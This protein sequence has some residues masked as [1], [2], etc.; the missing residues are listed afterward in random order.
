MRSQTAT[1]SAVKPAVK[2]AVTTEGL[3]CP[4]CAAGLRVKQGSSLNAPD[5]APHGR[6]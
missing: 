6:W 3:A 5:A 4:G 2:T 1:P